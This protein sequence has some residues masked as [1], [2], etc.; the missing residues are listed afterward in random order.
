MCFANLLHTPTF[1]EYLQL[2]KPSQTGIY[3]LQGFQQLSFPQATIILLIN[4]IL[5]PLQEA[6]V[7]IK[8]NNLL[9][10][11]YYLWYKHH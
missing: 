8:S 2:L 10:A 5:D 11:A 6:A 9:F 3:G 1:K 7:L 4:L